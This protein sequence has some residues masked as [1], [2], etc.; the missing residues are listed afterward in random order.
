MA[1]LTNIDSMHKDTETIEVEKLASLD[2]G[3]V[4]KNL[5]EGLTEE[6]KKVVKRAT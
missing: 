2:V 4:P 1:P 6:E 3:N 5:N